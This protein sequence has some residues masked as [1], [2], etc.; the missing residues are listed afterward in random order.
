MTEEVAHRDVPDELVDEHGLP[1][2]LCGEDLV[3]PGEPEDAP[4]PP[5]AG[6]TNETEIPNTSEED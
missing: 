3:P 1:E 2:E 6:A 4:D 5:E